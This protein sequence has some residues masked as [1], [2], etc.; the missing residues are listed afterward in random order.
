MY[1][2]HGGLLW[3]VMSLMALNSAFAPAHCDAAAAAAAAAATAAAA[4]SDD[5]DY[6]A[7][8]GVRRG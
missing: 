2:N 5:N 4:A 3:K 8:A 1:V 6:G 7:N